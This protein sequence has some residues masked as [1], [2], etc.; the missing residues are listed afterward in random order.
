MVIVEKQLEVLFSNNNLMLYSYG[1]LKLD[2]IPFEHKAECE[3]GA[4]STA[5]QYIAADSYIYTSLILLRLIGNY[6]CAPGSRSNTGD[7]KS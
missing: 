1:Q 6:K 5:H 7:I 4:L 2:F 3:K